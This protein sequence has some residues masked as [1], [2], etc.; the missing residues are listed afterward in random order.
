MEA[1]ISIWQKTGHFYFALTMQR[2]VCR[3]K[4][5]GALRRFVR[6]AN[7]APWGTILELYLWARIVANLL[8]MHCLLSA[9]VGSPDTS[10]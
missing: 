9:Q 1:D 2:S 7:G 6:S 3:Y 10:A 4:K 5:S 8:Q